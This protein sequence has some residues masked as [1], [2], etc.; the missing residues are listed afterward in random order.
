MHNLSLLVQL[1]RQHVS[2]RQ[3]LHRFNRTHNPTFVRP[4]NN[5]CILH[6]DAYRRQRETM[7]TEMGREVN[8][9][10]PLLST[11]DGLHT[12]FRYIN[13]TGSVTVKVTELRT[14]AV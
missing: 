1:R 13:D 2:L 9:L 3:H 11:Y 14:L 5:Y 8:L 4:A 7:R 10:K 6:C 12:L